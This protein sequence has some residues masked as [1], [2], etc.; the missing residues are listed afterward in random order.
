MNV[1]VGKGKIKCKK[2]ENNYSVDMVRLRI[3]VKHEEVKCYFNQFSCDPNVEYWETCRIKEYRHNWKFTSMDVFKGTSSFW[4]GYQHNRENKGLKYWLVIEYN[5]NKNCASEGFLGDI[6]RYFYSDIDRVEIVSVDLACDMP[7]N[8][9]NVFCDKGGKSI[10]KLFD[11]GGDNKTIYIG[12]GSGRIK[13]Y[14]KARELGLEGTNLTRYEIS[15]H[16]GGSLPCTIDMYDAFCEQSF[17]LV[18]IYCID[19]YQFD[20]CINETDRA[21]LYAVLNGYP[22]EA[23]SRRKKDNIEK[24]L[25]ES[26]GNTLESIGFVNAFKDYFKSYISILHK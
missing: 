12:E 10:K 15:V 9:N 19:S 2:V 11:Y 22:M 24:I 5:P 25:S 20:M 8:I 1:K 26:A 6:L 17:N 23:L 18:P 13:I 3:R 21:I 16:F 14:N 7:V 4:V